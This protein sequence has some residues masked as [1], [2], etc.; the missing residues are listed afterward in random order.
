M[1]IIAFTAALL[2]G[3]TAL[4]AQTPARSPCDCANTGHYECPQCGCA[5]ICPLPENFDWLTQCGP[6]GCYPQP[7][8]QQYYQPIQPQQQP[9][10]QP[11]NVP[12]WIL[13]AS[14]KVTTPRWRGSG[15]VWHVADGK[16]LVV[17]NKHVCPQALDGI[18]VHFRDG[19]KLVARWISADGTADL[20]MLEIAADASTKFVPVASAPPAR[21]APLWQI[22]YSNGGDP[23]QGQWLGA[24]GF[25]RYSGNVYG[26][27]ILVQPGDSGSGVYSQEEG[28]LIGLVYATN[29]GA[30]YRTPEIAWLVGHEDLAR[31]CT[32]CLPPR[33]G[34]YYQPIYPQP[35]APPK[36]QV[37]P[38]PQNPVPPTN[39]YYPLPKEPLPPATLPDYGKAIADLQS[40]INA[41][42]AVPGPPGPAGPQGPKGDSGPDL[43]PQLRELAII[44]AAMKTEMAQIKPGVQGPPGPA[45]PQGPAG[46]DAQSAHPPFI[47]EQ[48][49]IIEKK[50]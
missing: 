36:S 24:A 8:P 15:V 49:V 37:I 35:P 20:A 21:G 7:G 22:G 4:A 12:D 47:G 48:R 3:V 6:N 5:V 27:S 43:T 33:Q 16:A 40:Q 18:N 30:K 29:E 41:I 32:A 44:I 19:K 42:K 11:V 34:P 1:K 9:Q 28:R 46:K 38:P 14:V 17:T 23:K 31:Y 10:R 26:A 50:K 2:L 25:R 45:G 39:P 13:A